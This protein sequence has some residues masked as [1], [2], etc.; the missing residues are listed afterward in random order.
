M[1]SMSIM[2]I[3]DISKE[4]KDGLIVSISMWIKV[5]FKLYTKF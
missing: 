5:I 2:M 1:M 3:Y 4:E